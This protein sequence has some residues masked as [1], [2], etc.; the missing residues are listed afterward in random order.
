M[1][2]ESDGVM[3]LGRISQVELY[4]QFAESSI[5]LYPTEFYEISCINAMTAQAMGCIPV[6]TPVGALNETVNSKYGFKSDMN[7]ITDETIYLLSNQKELDKRRIKMSEWAKNKFN[8]SKLAK[9]WDEQF[10]G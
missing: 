7:R 10:N 4:K 3:E 2:S 5:W 6:C 9:E 8:A 1:I